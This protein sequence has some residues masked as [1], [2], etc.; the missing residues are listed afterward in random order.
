MML[1]PEAIAI[2]QCQVGIPS[3]ELLVNDTPDFPKTVQA[4]VTA[5]DFPLELDGKSLL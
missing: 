3:S 4:V 2:K 5:I 1:F